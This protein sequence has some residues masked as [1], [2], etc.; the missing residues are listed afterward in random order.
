[1]SNFGKIL[2]FVKTGA[3]KVVLHVPASIKSRNSYIGHKEITNLIKILLIV[4]KNN[5]YAVLTDEEI[6]KFGIT[7]NLRTQ[8]YLS[9]FLYEFSR[10]LKHLLTDFISRFS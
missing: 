5:N 3:K 6:S 4:L 9:N 8:C 10:K 7:A 2:N 1:M